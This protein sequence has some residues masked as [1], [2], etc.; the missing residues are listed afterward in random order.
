M[1]KRIKQ[2]RYYTDGSLENEPVSLKKNMLID[3][4]IFSNYAPISKIGIQTLPGVRFSLNNSNEYIIINNTG[5]FE[6]DLED[7]IQITS[8]RFFHESLDLLENA[9]HGLIVDFVYESEEQ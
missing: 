6:L 9:G 8:L 1:E 7:Q 5:I 2:V 3:G 4:T